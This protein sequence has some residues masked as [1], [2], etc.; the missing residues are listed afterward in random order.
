MA[1]RKKQMHPIRVEEMRDKI[2]ATLL[3]NKLENYALAD[4]MSTEH[5]ERMT[6]G[7]VRAALGLLNKII[8]NVTETKNEH[9]GPNGGLIPVSIKISFK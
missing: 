8:P 4:E 7:Q 3:I 9:S 5:E 1:A 2:R 6:D